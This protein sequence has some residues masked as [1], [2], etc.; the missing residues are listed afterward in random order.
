M[1]YFQHVAV[2]AD[3]RV[4]RS[5]ACFDTGNISRQYIGGRMRRSETADGVQLPCSLPLSLTFG[6]QKKRVSVNVLPLW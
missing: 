1:E 5:N 3:N 2:L 6:E 4:L